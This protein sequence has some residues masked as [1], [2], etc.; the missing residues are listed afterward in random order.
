APDAPSV[1]RTPASPPSYAWST[2]SAPGA[3]T[4]V[5]DPDAVPLAT[6]ITIASARRPGTAAV[7]RVRAVTVV[8]S[9]FRCEVAVAEW[10]G[11]AG[12]GG[13]P[14]SRRQGAVTAGPSP[15]RRP[16][17]TR[18]RAYVRSLIPEVP[19]A[20]PAPAR[21]A[22]R[23]RGRPSTRRTPV[24]RPTLSVVLLLL[25][26]AG[27]AAPPGRPAGEG[28]GRWRPRPGTGW[29]SEEH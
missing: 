9:R 5:P 22:G 11:S 10:C 29:R 27:C 7:L 20:F 26:L 24:R 21:P 15:V 28:G 25:L 3:T 8:N 6:P 13:R 2:A 19:S 14:E 4:G 16:P 18:L 17:G 1:S 12:P 23:S